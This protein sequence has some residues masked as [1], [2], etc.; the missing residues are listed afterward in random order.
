MLGS[1]WLRKTNCPNGSRYKHTNTD[2]KP[3]RIN[4][5]IRKYYTSKTI[6]DTEPYEEDSSEM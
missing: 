6:G 1:I 3:K 2:R 5:H 4:G